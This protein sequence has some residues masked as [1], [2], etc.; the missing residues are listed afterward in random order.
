VSISVNVT[1][2]GAAQS[3]EYTN[4]GQILANAVSATNTAAAQT[5]LTVPAGRTWLGSLALAATN[6]AAAGAT[7]IS[8]IATAGTGVVPAAGPLLKVHCSTVGTTAGLA[9]QNN[10]ISDVLVVAPAG[11][12]VTLTLTNS[13]ATTYTSDATAVGVLI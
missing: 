5:L 4:P 13:T 10:A 6:T 11:N 1:P 7:G 3:G 2:F 12:A 9:S 8:T